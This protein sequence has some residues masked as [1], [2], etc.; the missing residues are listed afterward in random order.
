MLNGRL[1]RERQGQNVAAV[2]VA[3]L[4]VSVFTGAPSKTQF[5]QSCVLRTVLV[6]C[7]FFFLLALM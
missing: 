6:M 4:S 7:L 2:V 1:R 3:Q 5:A